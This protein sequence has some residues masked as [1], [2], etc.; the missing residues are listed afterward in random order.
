MTIEEIRKGA[1]DG[2]THYDEQD[3]WKLK[4]SNWYIWLE[5]CKK[6]RRIFRYQKF[7]DVLEVK[8]I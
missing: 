3:Y 4:D 7:H 1:P 2:A 6:W 8:P 5:S